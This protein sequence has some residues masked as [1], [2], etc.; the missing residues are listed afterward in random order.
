MQ[1]R[2]IF[3]PLQPTPFIASLL[4][5][6]IFTQSRS[7]NMCVQYHQY[8]NI[9]WFVIPSYKKLVEFPLKRCDPDSPSTRNL[10][11]TEDDGLI[12][13]APKNSTK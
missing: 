3:L 4:F 5:V 8:I 2:L 11:E 10:V 9:S 13:W 1:P 7:R 12:N 6:S